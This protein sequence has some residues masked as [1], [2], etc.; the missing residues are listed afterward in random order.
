MSALEDMIAS[1]D[2]IKAEAKAMQ[3][4]HA[5]MEE[6]Q[7]RELTRA[8]LDAAEARGE[9]RRLRD[10]YEARI[11]SFAKEKQ[12]AQEELHECIEKYEAIK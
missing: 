1:V 10:E 6:A 3:Q 9:Y 12:R 8:K 5:D 7:N 11:R 4:Q 2:Q